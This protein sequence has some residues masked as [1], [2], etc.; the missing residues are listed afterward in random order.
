M[1]RHALSYHADA[2]RPP[3][4]LTHGGGI[5]T[6]TVS[7]WCAALSA[8]ARRRGIVGGP[9]TPADVDAALA[10]IRAAAEAVEAVLDDRAEAAREADAAEAAPSGDSLPPGAHVTPY[11]APHAPISDAPAYAPA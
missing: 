5:V 10:E 8:E 6:G 7:A 4:Q 2:Q 1:P 3:V 9:V 11:A